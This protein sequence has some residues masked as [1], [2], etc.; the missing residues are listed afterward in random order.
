MQTTL[1]NWDLELMQAVEW[2]NSTSKGLAQ[3]GL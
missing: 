3:Q 2:I 1:L